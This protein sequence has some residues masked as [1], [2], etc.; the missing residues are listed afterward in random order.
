MF[1]PAVPL[2]PLYWMGVVS[3]DSMS[4]LIHILMLPL[5]LVVMLRRRDEYAGSHA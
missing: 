1:A 4:A 3:A 2:L 5:M